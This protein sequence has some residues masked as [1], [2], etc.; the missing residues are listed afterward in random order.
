LKQCKLELGG[1]NPLIILADANMDYA[2]AAAAFGAF[3]HQGQICI[4]VGRVIVEQPIAEE[5]AAR[6]AKK[7]ASLPVGDPRKR[8]TV[9]GPLINDEAVRKVDGH[10]KDAVSK[11][12]RLLTGGTYEGRVYRPTVLADVRKD[13]QVYSEETFG[14]VA[15]IIAVRDVKEALEVANYTA[16]LRRS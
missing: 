3:L 5:F 1:K 14:P 13:M 9:I 6:F 15:P 16:L 8:E 12:A 2:V 7:A 11:G 10:V 4:A